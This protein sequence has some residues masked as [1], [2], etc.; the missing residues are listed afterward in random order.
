MKRDNSVFS[1]VLAVLVVVAAWAYCYVVGFG[2]YKSKAADLNRITDE[3]TQAQSKYE[4]LQRTK[5]A[6]DENR[7][8]VTNTLVAV[9]N[10]ADTENVISE[11]EAIASQQQLVIPS[12]QISSDS[13]ADGAAATAS[14]STFGFTIT[15]SF[16]AINT[17]VKAVENDVKFMSIDS[18]TMSTTDKS[19]TA[20]FGVKVYT[21]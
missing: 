20:T 17:F 8:L 12:I 21:R 2:G 16:E 1:I 15:G 4:S 9:S 18:L 11:I 3:V 10:G 14:S 13:A 19:M 6:I 5:T 7:D